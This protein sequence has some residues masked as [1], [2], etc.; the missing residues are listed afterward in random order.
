MES[1]VFE[2]LQKYFKNNIYLTGRE[3]RI[4]NSLQVLTKKSLEQFSVK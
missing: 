1:Q 3:A 2:T 4:T